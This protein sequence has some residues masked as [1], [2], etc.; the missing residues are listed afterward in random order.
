MICFYTVLWRA[1][2]I[3]IYTNEKK[4]M[5]V[6]KSIHRAGA[7]FCMIF[8]LNM[9][10]GTVYP[11]RGISIIQKL[12]AVFIRSGWTT[13]DMFGLKATIEEAVLSE[14]ETQVIVKTADGETHIHDIV[15]CTTNKV[16][17]KPQKQPSNKVRFHKLIQ[18][19]KRI[20]F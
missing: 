14:D 18:K 4:K 10:T 11:V 3:I 8:S 2:L 19:H 20:R 12:N 16:R 6:Q 17:N 9:V 15:D 13:I 7:M 1:P 5:N